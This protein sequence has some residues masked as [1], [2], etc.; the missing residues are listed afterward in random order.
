LDEAELGDR[1][2]ALADPR[3]AAGRLRDVRPLKGVRGV[4]DGALARVV[5]ETWTKDRPDPDEDR[6]ALDRLFGAAFEDGLLA[7]G[8]VAALVPDDPEAAW[9]IGTAWLERVDDPLTAD[10]LGWLVLGPSVL[11]AGRPVRDL[12]ALVRPGA[13]V[14]TRRAVVTAGL[15]LTPEPLQGPAAAALRARVGDRHVRLVEGPLRDG[16]AAIA[17]AFVRD[18]DPSVRKALRRI[19]RTWAKA[20]PVGLVAWADQ[21]RG[22]IPRLL[23]EEVDKA[24]RRA[25]RSA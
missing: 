3:T 16:L 15:A 21:V 4:A 11:A 24:R 17:D 23:G 22:G 13:H 9:D 20:D 6:G 10:A 18:E 7:I 12:L 25:A 2:E 8:L 19:V 1:L 5:A 14:A